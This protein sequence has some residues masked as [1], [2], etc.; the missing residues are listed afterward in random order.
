MKTT[1]KT[2]NVWAA[3]AT[4]RKVF[5]NQIDDT[6]DTKVRSLKY[7]L[8]NSFSA[9]STFENDLNSVVDN[10][11]DSKRF[12]NECEDLKLEA[13]AVAQNVVF[14]GQKTFNK[15]RDLGVKA[16]LGSRVREFNKPLFEVVE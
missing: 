12:L 4:G 5:R 1:N 14:E 15:V 13:K 6:F 11:C 2:A 8:E 10:L 3:V 16:V 9:Y 7:A